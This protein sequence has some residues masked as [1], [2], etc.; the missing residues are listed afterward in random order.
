MIRPTICT[1]A[2]VL[3][4][5]L[6]S[7][8][9]MPAQT[10]GRDWLASSRQAREY[11]VFGYQQ[12]TLALR[13]KIELELTGAWNAPPYSVSQAHLSQMQVTTIMQA[14][15]T[16][17]EEAG[18]R[19]GPPAVADVITHLYADPANTMIKWPAMVE[20]ATMTLVGR[21]QSEINST[22]ER[23]RRAAVPQENQ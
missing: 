20:I 4:L 17:Y 23:A 10:A 5:A 3:A 6:C 18:L 8:S 19:F 9:A 2:V 11:F 7:V 16:L 21:P 22:L 15:D 13:S 12:G 1:P 14:L